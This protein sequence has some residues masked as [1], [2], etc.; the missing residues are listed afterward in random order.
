MNDRGGG[1][2]RVPLRGVRF[3][4]QQPDPRA[5]L[6]FS[7]S[8]QFAKRK[9]RVFTHLIPRPLLLPWEAKGSY[10][11]SRLRSK[12]YTNAFAVFF[13]SSRLCVSHAHKIRLAF[14]AWLPFSRWEDSFRTRTRTRT[15]CNGTRT[16]QTLTSVSHD[17]SVI[18]TM[19]I[20]VGS[21]TSTA[22]RSTSTALLSTTRTARPNLSRFSTFFVPYVVRKT[23][24]ARVHPP[25]PPAASPPLVVEGE[26]RK[27]GAPLQT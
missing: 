4:P 17:L 12:H 1:G 23:Q 9:L 15:Q 24:T 10:E 21:S 3:E 6:L 11:K 26:L 27:V 14:S 13:A 19:E 22:S 20:T 25:H 18:V 16:R 7:F 2:V 8:M 5:S